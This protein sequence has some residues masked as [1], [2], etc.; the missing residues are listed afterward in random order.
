MAMSIRKSRSAIIS[1]F[2]ALLIGSL[3]SAAW[4]FQDGRRT[5]ASEE[6][7]RR[8]LEQLTKQLQ[9]SQQGAKPAPAPLVQQP[10]APVPPAIPPAAAAATRE[11]G[12]VL[13]NLENADLMDFINQVAAM[14]NLAPLVVDPDVKGSV[15]LSSG[16][17]SKD[18]IMPLFSMILKT[19]NAAL[20]RQGNIYQVIPIS[21][22]LKRGVDIIEQMPFAPPV[23][24]QPEIEKGKKPEAT[25]PKSSK[26]PTSGATDRTSSPSATPFQPSP[27]T[28]RAA[29]QAAEGE[30]SKAPRLATHVIRVEFIPVKDL[31]EPLKLFMTST[32]GAVI[33]PY[34]RLNMLILTDYTDNV[35]R[36]LQIIH[37]LDNSYLDPDLV[38][39]VKINNNASQDV[40]DD[41]KKLFGSGA[42][43]SPT[44]VTFISLDRLNAIFVMASSR[45]AL[46]EVKGWIRE[47]DSSS[48]KN[49]Q[50]YIYIVE[51][52]TASYI[53]MM[54]SALYGGDQTFTSSSSAGAGGQAGG[55]TVSG[56]ARGSQGTQQGSFGGANVSGGAASSPFGGQSSSQSSQMGGFGGGLGGGSGSGGYFA[57]SSFG[58]GRQ[59][60]PQLNTS[61]NVSSMILRGGQFTG[62]QDTVRLVV[63]DINNSLIIQ[64]TSADYT[65]ISETIRK[66]DVLP[67]QALIDARIFEVDLTDSLNLGISASLDPKG[68]NTNTLTTGSLKNGVLSAQTFM[69][70]GNSRELL[71]TLNALRL[72]TKVKLLEAPSV[73][74]LDGQQASIIV[75]AEIP[76]AAGSFTT[77]AGSTSNIQYRDTGISLLVIPR[78]SASG[79]V[80][81]DLT[82]EVSAPTGTGDTPSFSKTSVST[83]LTV[84]D[85]E[86]V[87]IAGLIRD[88]SNFSRSGIPFLSQ[89]PLLGNL[90]G[91]TSKSTHRS[92]LIILITPHV[93]RT[94]QKLEQMTQE[95]R[96]S[97][98]HV[99]K[100][101][102]EQ[103]NELKEDMENA[104][105]KRYE[106]NQKKLKKTNAQPS[107]SESAKPAPPPEPKKPE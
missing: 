6:D 9:E 97:L 72:K 36:M 50:T 52:S 81:L 104:R 43:D 87:A 32:E 92:E 16:S 40:V 23:T 31:I 89:I 63:D 78:I 83:T 91:T 103:E 75:G 76:Y 56:G 57:G 25:S 30:A 5:P 21:T 106:Q 35:A 19:N 3:S 99:S 15:N 26:E 70:I 27:K 82:Q 60:G 74:A 64:A 88:G 98:R 38:E 20:I 65:Y 41:L 47:L 59:L 73:L 90:F 29:T 28:T 8:A 86:T 17:I 2:A 102:D 54:L 62:L 80:T 14:L 11:S 22:A 69:P 12:K 44:G 39:L 66:M 45:R 34:E 85:G 10:A 93:I 7:R 67:R 51:N 49:I 105:R 58:A 101:A 71:A 95:L 94:P 61:R 42:K 100:Y 4:T 48:A 1:V 18:D 84:K 107:E 79:S 24:P 96:D 46:E 77:T 13:L 37:M 55:G 68:T 33:M 53:A